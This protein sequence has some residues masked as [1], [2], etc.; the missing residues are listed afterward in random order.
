[1]SLRHG[2]AALLAVLAACLLLPSVASAREA[3]LT[4]AAP[5]EGALL[6]VA[7]TDETGRIV[8]GSPSRRTDDP[9]VVVVP[10]PDASTGPY[11]VTWRALSSDGDVV[12]GGGV[13]AGP[14]VLGEG[15]RPEPDL[16]PLVIA[17]RLLLLASPVVLLGL[18]V[19][20]FWIVGAAGGH[21]VGHAGWWGA[22]WCAA[23]AG[24]LGLVLA[25]VAQLDAL[26][27]GAGGLAPLLGDTRWGAAWIVQGAALALAC[28]A[29]GALGRG[30]PTPLRAVALVA[31]PA[32][33]LG[34]IAWSGHASGGGDRA[35]GIGA[36]VLHGWATGAWLGGLVGLFVLVVPALRRLGDAARVPVAAAVV[37]RFSTLAVG[38]VAVLVVTGVYRA[39]AELSA[40]D[41][42]GD[43]S[44][45]R[46][47]LVK[48]GVFAGMLAVG[49]YNRFVIH[50]RL[51]RAALG[52]D[53]TDRG[54]ALALR[55]SVG[56]E[57]GLAAAAMLAVAV[58]VSLPPPA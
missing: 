29:A 24:F 41:D 10:I 47:L 17:G 53:P 55:R 56:A 5:V 35:I 31:G 52:L 48:L 19:V 33:A 44:Y 28:A 16:R 7:V 42:L 46:A 36:D 37:V 45:G 54:A 18:A 8:S 9:T 3:V 43:T 49:A 14:A 1:M 4:F 20:R 23:G 34:A 11:R 57:L 40:L 32:L 51:E 6:K 12:R 15:I 58:L 13:V 30:S 39:L 38:A 50:P 22:W 27:P 21:A 26:D 2:P 25:P